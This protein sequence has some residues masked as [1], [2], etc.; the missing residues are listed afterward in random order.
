MALLSGL[1]TIDLP[2]SARGAFEH[3]QR[4]LAPLDHAA[5]QAAAARQAQL[6]KPPGSLGRLEELAT[7]L[8]GIAGRVPPPRPL[9]AVVTVFAGDHGVVA[10]GVTPWPSEV[11]GQMVAN[12]LR[13][14]AAVNVL[15]RRAGAEVVVVDV[16]VASPLAPGPGLVSARI[17]S[18]TA[19]LARGPAMTLEETRAAL[20]LGSAVAD[21][22]AGAGAACLLTGDMGIGNTTPSA[23]L[24]AA[25]TGHEASEVTGRGTG[26]DDAQLARK[27]RIVAQAVDRLGSAADPLE[28]LAEVGGLEIAALAGYIVGAAAARRPVLLDGVIAVAAALVA[29]ALAPGCRPYLVAG[30]RSA[31][32]GA[33]VGLRHLGLEPLVDLGLRLGEGSG[34]CLALPIL[35]AAACLLADM[36]TFHE[37]G[38]HEGPLA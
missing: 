15:A 29:V 16:G 20:D 38:V 23:C 19:N 17:R 25:L 33:T 6:T 27:Q 34:A 3:A 4:Q 2:G 31:E 21:H 10:E 13:G 8:A 18:G 28:V 26:V 32:P 1:A 36:A 37:A 22:L 9:P 35:D 24:I 12:F 30:H 7:Q 11:T 5:L 14:G